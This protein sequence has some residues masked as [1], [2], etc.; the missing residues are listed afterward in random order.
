MTTSYN[1]HSV[2]F[3][4]IIKCQHYVHVHVHKYY[5]VIYICKII[6]KYFKQYISSYY[7]IQCTCCYHMYIDDIVG[8][9]TS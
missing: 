9:T 2:S 5:D 6:Y 3:G 7:T 8:L 1:G 4:Y